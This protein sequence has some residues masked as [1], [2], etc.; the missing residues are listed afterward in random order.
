MVVAGPARTP[1][2]LFLLYTQRLLVLRFFL[3]N[4]LDYLL[5]GVELNL[6][7]NVGDGYLRVDLSNLL[8]DVNY[9]LLPVHLFF[10]LF[11]Q[12]VSQNLFIR[13]F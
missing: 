10:Q 1:V 13:C 2:L 12:T 11:I 8:N 5:V 9:V 4:T 3:V 6:D 7:V